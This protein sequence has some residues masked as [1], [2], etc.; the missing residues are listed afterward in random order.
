MID[1]PVAGEELL[2][3]WGVSVAG[4]LNREVQLMTT[5]DQSSNGT[6]L[7]DVTGLTFAVTS[8][9][10]YAGRVRLWYTVSAT[11]QGC[12]VGVACPAGSVL[13]TVTTYGQGSPSGTASS[14]L[15][16]SGSATGVTATDDNAGRRHILVEFDYDCTAG[17][18]FAIQFRRG[19]TSGSTGAT[20]RKGS[21][22]KVLVSA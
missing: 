10:Q 5:A 8:G 4:Q 6:T 3:D 22:G 13:A 15:T 17:G 21:G 12:Q 1:V 20:I 16:A 11:N 18:T 2:D 7:A 19:G 9:K 14:V